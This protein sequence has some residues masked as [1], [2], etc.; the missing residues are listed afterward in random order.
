M[1]KLT[2]DTIKRLGKTQKI[3]VLKSLDSTGLAKYSDRVFCS[4]DYGV[5]SEEFASY[6]KAANCTFFLVN[7]MKFD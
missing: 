6:S 7:S 3:A 2:F 5:E 4:W 1:V